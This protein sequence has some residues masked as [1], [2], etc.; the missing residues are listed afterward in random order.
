MSNF[1][2]KVKRCK[3]KTTPTYGVRV[4]CGHESLG[5]PGG[6]EW[7]CGRCGV[8]ITDDPSGT[9]AGMSG[10]PYQRWKKNQRY[11]SDHADQERNRRRAGASRDVDLPM[12]LRRTMRVSRYDLENGIAMSCGKC[13]PMPTSEAPTG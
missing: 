11:W 5:C 10:W 3:H 12:W 2:T 7:H 6:F 8:Y 1:W 13:E 9:V 4:A